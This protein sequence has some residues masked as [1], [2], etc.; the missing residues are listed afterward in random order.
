MHQLLTLQS[1]QTAELLCG[2][3]RECKMLCTPIFPVTVNYWRR[4]W[5]CREKIPVGEASV[6]QVEREST[7]KCVWREAE[8]RRKPQDYAPQGI[9]CQGADKMCRMQ[10]GK[11]IEGS[12]FLEKMM[13]QQFKVCQRRILPR[14]KG[15]KRDRSWAFHWKIKAS[16]GEKGFS[17]IYRDRLVGRE[18]DLIILM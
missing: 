4:M 11:D 7:P 13:R 5:S 15:N 18:R 16:L 10:V 8:K 12:N 3:S 6:G 14:R 9:L 17:Y 2:T 1:F